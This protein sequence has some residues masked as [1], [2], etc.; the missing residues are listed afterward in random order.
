MPATEGGEH[1]KAV[2]R[3][4]NRSVPGIK[5][6]CAVLPKASSSQSVM[7]FP[8]GSAKTRSLR[9]AWF[10]VAECLVGDRSN[11]GGSCDTMN[12]QQRGK[13]HSHFDC[14]GQISKNREREGNGPDHSVG[15]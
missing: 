13:Q 15:G 5:A 1:Q 12:E 10:T 7:S 9:C 4:R 3:R 11:G 2:L 6:R 8:S 14:H